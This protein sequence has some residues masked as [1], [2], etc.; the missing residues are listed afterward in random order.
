MSEEKDFGAKSDQQEKVI[1]IDRVT[2]VVKGGKNMRF[3]ATVV[4]GDLNGKVGVG[5]SK[6]LEVPKAIRKAIEAARKK[7]VVIK[8]IGTTIAHEVYGK[9]GASKVV[10]KPARK[11]TGVIAGGAIRSVLE[12]V[13]LKDVVAKSLGS[14]NPIN[15]A[16]ATI[17]A[18]SHILDRASIEALRG[19]K[20]FVRQ[21]KELYQKPQENVVNA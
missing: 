7:Q 18:L 12:L 1:S 10:V 21:P 2:K 4:V 15:S 6:A 13:G 5:V 3:R 11:G 9:Y 17:D 16:R 20:I 19:K 14:T 8:F